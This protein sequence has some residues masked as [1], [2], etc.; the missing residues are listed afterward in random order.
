MVTI[1]ITA[2]NDVPVATAASVTT[3]E[4]TAVDI[5]LIASDV[6]DVSG[7]LTYTVTS[8]PSNGTVLVNGATATYTPNSDYNGV[9]SF[10]FEATDSEGA[11]STAAVVT[12]TII[13]VNDAPVANAV[14]VT[15]S[16][17]TAVDIVLIASDV[18]DVSG[19]LTYTV[20]SESSNGTVVV[21]GAT[22]TYTPTADYNGADSFSFQ[23]TDSDG[24]TS[25][26]AVVTITITAVNDVPVAN[27]AS[28][29]TIEDTA[30]DI[31]LIA[32]DVED[33]SGSLTYIVTSEPS[34]GT[35]VVN[36][37]TATYTPNSDYNG[38][39]SFSFEVIDSDGA[40][41]TAAVVTITITAVNDAPVANAASV[42]TSEDTAVD[43][44]LIASDVEDVSGSLTY[45]V[46]SESS[47]GTV[48]VNGATATY[49]PTADYNGADSFSFQVTDSDGL[50]S[51]VAVV[52]ITIT[53]VNDAPVANAASVTT[54]ED[55]AVDIGLIASDV[56]DVSGSLTYTVTSEPSNGTV[57]VN[58]AT[59]TYTPTADYNGAD[60]FSFQVT[61]SDGLTSTAAVVTITITAVNDVPVATAASV[62]TSEDTAVDIELIASDVEDVSG[63]LTYTVTSEPSNGTVVFNG[64]TATYTPNSDYNGVDSF[65]FE[66]TDSEGATSTAAVVTITITAVNDAPVANA[67]SVT[68]SEDTALAIALTASDAEDNS[69]SLTY[70]LSTTP[71]NGTVVVNGATATYTPTADYNGADSFSFQVTDSDGLTSTVA[72]VTITITAVND[73]PVATAA[74]VTTIEDTAVDIG[75]IAS[76]VEDVSGSLT[77]T[78]TSEPSNGTVLVNGATATYTPNSDYNGTDSFSFEATDSEGATS[79]A[80]VVTITITAVNDA[81]VANAVSVTTSEDTALAIA[82]TAS[83]AEDNS[84]SLTYALSTTPS[85]GTVVVNGATATYTPNADYNGV[86]SFSFQVTDSDG[87]TSTAAVV[88]ITI[89]AV[90][91]VPVATAASVTT[92]EDIAVDIGLIASDVEDVSGSLTYTV[93]SEPS[94]GTVLVNGATATYT[95]NSDY[96]GVD[97]FSFE[98]IDSDGATSTAA[99][100]TITIT[101]VNDAPVANAA[102]V[103]TSEDT[104]VDIVLIASDVE[105]VSGSLTYTVTSESSNGTVVV[106]GATATYTPTADYNGADSFSFQVTDSDGLTSTVAVVTITITAVNDVPVANAAS[107]TTSEDTVVDIALI[108][109]DVEDVSGSLTYTVTS[110]PSNGTVLVNGATA[111]YT[112]TADYNGVDSFSFEVIDSEGATSTAAVVTITIT[113]VNDV[114][115]AN[116]LYFEYTTANDSITIVLNA[117][118]SDGDSLNYSVV[119]QPAIGSLTGTPPNL[120]YSQVGISETSFIFLVSD[121]VASVTGTVNIVNRLLTTTVIND[122]QIDLSWNSGIYFKLYAVDLNNSDTQ[123]ILYEGTENSY[124]NIGLAA[125]TSYSYQIAYCSSASNCNQPSDVII[126]TTPPRLPI[127]TVLTLATISTSQINSSWIT[128]A[129][130]T[131]YRLYRSTQTDGIFSEQYAGTNTAYNDLNLATATSYYYQLD[132]CTLVTD[133]NSCVRTNSVSGGTSPN[134][135]ASFT[136]TFVASANAITVSW[137]VSEGSY[138]KLNSSTNDLDYTE[139]YANTGNNY[140]II[141]LDSASTFYY[142]LQICGHSESCL[143]LS[144][145]SSAIAA[146]V[147]DIS[148]YTSYNRNASQDFNTLDSN[149]TEIRGIWSDGTTMWILDNQEEKIFAYSLS[150]KL[151]DEGKDIDV[152]VSDIDPFDIWSDGATMWV[153]DSNNREILAFD[154]RTN[155]RDSAKDFV[156]LDQINIEPRGIWS[157]GVTMWVTNV[158]DDKVYAYNLN[159]K[160]RES[161]KDFNTLDAVGNNSPQAI[162]SDGDILWVVDADKDAAF[163]YNLNSKAHDSNHTFNTALANSAPLGIGSANNI[164]WVSDTTD[165]KL[166]AYDFS[167]RILINA[168]TMDEIKISWAPIPGASYYIL[169]SST[170]FD[171]EYSEIYSGNLRSFFDSNLTSSSKHYYQLSACT[172]DIE[173]GSCSEVFG[174]NSAYTQPDENAS[175]TLTFNLVEQNNVISWDVSEGSYFILSSSTDSSNYSQIFAGNNTNYQHNIL[176]FGNTYYYKL[177][178]C[179]DKN[180]CLALADANTVSIIITPDTSGYTVNGA[181]DSSQ[182]FNKIDVH[183]DP[184]GIWSD[185]VTSW[186]VDGQNDGILAYSLAT[187]TRLTD[188]DQD[189]TLDQNNTTPYGIWSDG[190]TMWVVDINSPTIFAYNF[191]TKMRDVGKDFSLI[192]V[193]N[194]PYAI[195]SDGTTMWVVDATDAKIYAYDLNTKSYTSDK[196]FNTLSSSG[197]DS[198]SGIWSDGE[199][200]WVLD[201]ADSRIFAYNLSTKA[202]DSSKDFEDLINNNPSHIWSDGETMW[203]V[204]GG[205]NIYA[206]KFARKVVVD[207]IS[208]SEIE[209]SWETADGASH[210]IL[211]SSTQSEGTYSEIYAGSETVTV[212][213]GLTPGLIYYYQLVACSIAADMNTCSDQFGKNSGSTLDDNASYTLTF[214]SNMSAT[215]VSWVVSSGSYFRLYSSTTDSNYSEIYAGTDNLYQNTN[216]D[217]ASSYYYRLRICNTSDNCLALADASTAIAVTTPD[218]TAY[219]MGGERNSGQDFDTLKAAGNTSPYGLWSD[220]TTTWVVD[221]MLNKIFAYNTSTKARDSDK[222]FDNLDAANTSAS[223]I[224]SDGSTMWVLQFGASSHKIFAYNLAT[225][226]YESGKDIDALEAIGNNSSRGIWSDGITMWVVDIVDDKVYGYNLISK[227]YDSSQT[228]NLNNSNENASGIWSDGM[229]IWGVRYFYRHDIRL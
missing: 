115:V 184:T 125:A 53:A 135:D 153:L 155:M 154:M 99:V 186:L 59:A 106:N 100:V 191:A 152:V 146:T 83:D 50:T 80:A 203:V 85:N 34:N 116:D 60:S 109:S 223:D 28:V 172:L 32:S 151:R 77:Y 220:G 170:Q 86:D 185:G 207:A 132:L 221:T 229:T 200:M 93:T 178:I 217:T 197:N 40:S 187:K 24:L 49:T 195:W 131:Y 73:V 141:G 177:Q 108:A 48:V 94:N 76:D 45:T 96:N 107:V 62:T 140:Q 66:A 6:E 87:L 101:A 189:F 208:S 111:T 180:S 134:T 20:T 198:P 156:N 193:N 222:D 27:A 112:P 173:D 219:T 103:T 167:Y 97:S 54:S 165:N 225:K 162:W 164:L 19:S 25:T 78:V 105:D 92:I 21:N 110:E 150:D 14:S 47:N 133:S 130:A 18:E 227:N 10:S 36:G 71:S 179:G 63:S 102:S 44:V 65:S 119:T 138:F 168:L 114:P 22:A 143:A 2:V 188:T 16:E 216:L 123:T 120:V 42:T 124:S 31:G 126:A 142:K 163:A 226:A 51:T 41:S 213:S 194:L 11:T 52:T 199:T 205:D 196:D 82:L 5:G 37:A 228:F 56:E 192:S 95:P 202:R 79:T 190:T 13:A 212:N 9:D 169:Y 4:D 8:E 117:S 15:T 158:I 33:V 17:D 72:V 218:V 67:V 84:A 46:T 160:M 182:D 122:V 206:Y 7:S 43:I 35:V 121:G 171:G 224:W 139:I 214:V 211:S 209:I 75:L 12:I 55:T 157:D 98:V 104:A 70:A 128:V 39:D 30:V 113:A 166:Y 174:R 89:T 148:D 129:G 90:N 61:D 69:A 29:T 136:L 210:Y 144:S 58:G 64:T 74:S 161:G 175:Y 118:D 38:V 23:V 81:P 149:N 147:P 159:D 57:L 26:V 204:G 1:T 183:S 68:T 215:S 88:T 181:R 127:N 91:D 176:E 201:I 145:V 137:E 3:I